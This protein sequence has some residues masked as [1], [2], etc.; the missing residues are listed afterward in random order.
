MWVSVKRVC[1][2]LGILEHGQIAKLKTKTWAGT[3]MIC[4]PSPGGPQSAFRIS[5]DSLPMW[6]ATIGAV[7]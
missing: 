2:P 3:Q 1:E 5:L 7:A 4:V 6:L